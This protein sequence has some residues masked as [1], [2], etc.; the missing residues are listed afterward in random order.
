[1]IRSDKRN[2]IQIRFD[3]DLGKIVEAELAERIKELKKVRLFADY[4][5]NGLRLMIDL[6]EK[7]TDVLLELFPWIADTFKA[8]PQAAS[9]TDIERQIQYLQQLILANAGVGNETQ[10]AA[11]RQPSAAPVVKA[12]VVDTDAMFDDFM[13]FIQ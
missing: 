6:S 10:A 4:V 3:L 7:K 13:S 1:M 11:V 9:S 5:R 8:Q 12:A 2:R